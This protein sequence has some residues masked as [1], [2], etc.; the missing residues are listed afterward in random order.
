M[1]NYPSWDLA[2]FIEFD[3]GKHTVLQLEAKKERPS[4]H[5]SMGL[6]VDLSLKSLLRSC[7]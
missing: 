7:A 5:G 1:V 6:D 3:P 2:W 4:F